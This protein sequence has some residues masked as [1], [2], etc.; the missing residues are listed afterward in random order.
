MDD[1]TFVRINKFVPLRKKNKFVPGHAVDW[2]GNLIGQLG[3][4]LCPGGNDHCKL[5]SSSC[6]IRK[7][8]IT[9]LIGFI[10]EGNE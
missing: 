7:G 6:Q 5:T 1:V 4:W 8:Y 2:H 10:T 9:H 3:Q